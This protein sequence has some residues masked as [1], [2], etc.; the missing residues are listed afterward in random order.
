MPTSNNE[1]DGENLVVAVYN[2]EYTVQ[3]HGSVHSHFSHLWC[4]SG[5]NHSGK[6]SFSIATLRSKGTFA[7]TS[8]F[9]GTLAA[10]KASGL[11]PNSSKFGMS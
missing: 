2:R 5:K 11:W 8:S 4:I 7:F 1:T 9:N 10:Q 3:Y 6:L